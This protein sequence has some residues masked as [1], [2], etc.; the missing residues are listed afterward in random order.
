MTLLSIVASNAIAVPLCTTHPSHELRYIIDQSDA[1]MLLSSDMF[2]DKAKEVL[3]EGTINQPI[4]GL[5]TI[6]EGSQS[7]ERVE[8]VEST[9]NAGGLMLYTSGT[10][11]RPV[12]NPA[13]I[14]DPRLTPM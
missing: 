7:A 9:S 14:N 8:L 10:T 12:S 2:K 6:L 13:R 5:N 1:M 4:I 11:S 3:S